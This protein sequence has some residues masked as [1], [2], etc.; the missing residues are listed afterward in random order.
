MLSRVVAEIRSAS[1]LIFKTYPE[2]FAATIKSVLAHAVDHA[3]AVAI[4]LDMLVFC[5]SLMVITTALD[6]IVLKPVS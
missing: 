4:A 1:V 5:V 3:S 6:F 2:V